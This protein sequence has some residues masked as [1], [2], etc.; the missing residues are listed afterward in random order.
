MGVTDCIARSVKGYAHIALHL[1]HSPS[2]RS[3]LSARIL[4]QVPRLFKDP[5]AVREWERFLTTAAQASVG[6]RQ[7]AP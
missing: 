3:A 4:A 1:A 5:L 6:H 2:K 7:Q